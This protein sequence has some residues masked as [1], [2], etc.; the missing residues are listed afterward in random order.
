[1]CL[2][3][4]GQVG[5]E[6]IRSYGQCIDDIE[7]L[8][9]GNCIVIGSSHFFFKLKR[10]SLVETR[11]ILFGMELCSKMFLDQVVTDLLFGLH[12]LNF[13]LKSLRLFVPM[14]L[15]QIEHIG[16]KFSIVVLPP[17]AWDFT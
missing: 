10:T 16:L 1:M 8:K 5:T 7:F 13:F 2:R 17:L 11:N 4:L 14:D 9:I 12:K 3:P 6:K 15:L